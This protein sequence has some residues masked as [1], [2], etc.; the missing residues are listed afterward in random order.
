MMMMRWMSCGAF[1]LSR[2][3]KTKKIETRGKGKCNI[4][5]VWCKPDIELLGERGVG[6]RK[7]KIRKDV[8]RSA[9]V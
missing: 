6:A 4:N 3:Q 2:L 1:F 8:F 9:N 7:V 5:I